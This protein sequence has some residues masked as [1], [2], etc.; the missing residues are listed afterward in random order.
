MVLRAQPTI[1]FK[2]KKQ[3]TTIGAV[4][5]RVELEQQAGSEKHF[6]MRNLPGHILSAVQ[7]WA[8]VTQERMASPLEHNHLPYWREPPQGRILEV[9]NL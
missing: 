6:Y 8:L 3:G 1:Y 9:G 2:G 7:R 4:K 5:P